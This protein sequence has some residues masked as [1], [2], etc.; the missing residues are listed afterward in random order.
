MNLLFIDV[1][2]G[3]MILLTL[4]A[5]RFNSW[6]SNENKNYS[7]TPKEYINIFRYY[8]FLSV[9]LL[10]FV[11]FIFILKNAYLQLEGGIISIPEAFYPKLQKLV[12]VLGEGSI[13]FI[14]LFLCSLLNNNKIKEYDEIWRDYLLVIARIPKNV[15]DMKNHFIRKRESFKPDKYKLRK[16]F[17]MKLCKE[18]SDYW[19]NVYKSI[20]A[21]NEI[22]ELNLNYVKAQ[23]LIY[24]IKGMEY[25]R[26]KAKANDIVRWGNEIDSIG[27][28]IPFVNEIKVPD[29][30]TE[31]KKS[32]DSI[33]LHCYELIC[34]YVVQYYPDTEHQYRVLKRFGLEPKFSDR[35]QI[36][37]IESIFIAI[38]GVSLLSLLSLWG[39]FY[40]NDLLQIQGPGDN[41]WLDY[42]RLFRWTLA[43]VL[44]YLVSIVLAVFIKKITENNSAARSRMG[45]YLITGVLATIGSSSYFLLFRQNFTTD[46]IGGYLFLSISLGAIALVAI[47]SL[48]NVNT[49][50]KKEVY[51]SAL[52]IASIF[53]F[54]QAF[55]QL[56]VKIGF[57]PSH[58]VFDLWNLIVSYDPSTYISLVYGFVKGF[59]IAFTISYTIQESTRIQL[60]K[61]KRVNPRVRYVSSM[62]T[63]SGE[64]TMEIIT[65]NISKSGLL[66]QGRKIL[67]M[68]KNIT[69][70]F[71]NPIGEVVGVIIWKTKN[72]AGVCFQGYKDQDN[73]TE[74][75]RH[76]LQKLHDYIRN[77]Y[78]E[79]YA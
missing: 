50:N 40:V 64:R 38:T 21:E 32:I 7:G 2:L 57:S 49:T 13:T 66:I 62:E 6:T 25:S 31:K 4:I 43:S 33:L 22:S 77:N 20:N 59:L 45:A 68:K 71:P 17:D 54:V 29:I 61:A 63:K 48:D 37:Y 44:C 36:K 79:Y 72:F 10:T 19:E 42:S 46:A 12:S 41:P 55:L 58:T 8:Y 70:M 39:F 24:E 73:Q 52:K 51:I 26:K 16:L 35:V 15:E 78:G 14:S 56:G 18:N 11:L 60:A 30:Y 28:E 75:E 74:L 76:N 67:S 3:A 69:L 34:K 5:P 27:K 1:F 53:G 23:Y 47:Y 9:Y 65:R